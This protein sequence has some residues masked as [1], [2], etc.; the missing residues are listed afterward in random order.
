MIYDGTTF[1]GGSITA[2]PITLAQAVKVHSLQEGA[3]PPKLRYASNDRGEMYGIVDVDNR[4]SYKTKTVPALA[5]RW[6]GENQVVDVSYL[7]PDAPLLEDSKGSLLREGEAALLADANTSTLYSPTAGG[8]RPGGATAQPNN[9]E[10]DAKGGGTPSGPFGFEYG[11][12]REQII[13]LIG[14]QAVKETKGDTMDVT[15]APKPHPAFERYILIVSPDKGLLAVSALG[16]GHGDKCLWRGSSQPVCGT[17]R[18]S[19]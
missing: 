11:M 8:S 13:K 18:L 15:T 16:K 19:F 3:R 2:P 4:I 12:T 14:K 9:S 5:P 7:S 10:A 1:S 6:I 17:P